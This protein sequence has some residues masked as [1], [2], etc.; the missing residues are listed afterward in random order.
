MLGR[1]PG[2]MSAAASSSSAD[3]GASG[4]PTAASASQ[5]EPKFSRLDF[6]LQQQL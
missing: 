2:R 4:A 5:G 1:Q 3:G 6:A